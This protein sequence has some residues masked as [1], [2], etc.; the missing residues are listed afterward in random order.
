MI[1]P[2]DVGIWLLV[3][4]VVGLTMLVVHL[5]WRN[6]YVRGWRASRNQPPICPECGY[7]LSGL[8]HCRCPECGTEYTLD[9]LWQMPVARFETETTGVG[10]LNQEKHKA[11]A[12]REN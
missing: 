8:T 1:D 3:V 9:Q 11:E 10:R 6:G 5:I 4:L 2:I 12:T 7:N